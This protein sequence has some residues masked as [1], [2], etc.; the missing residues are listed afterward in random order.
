MMV[1]LIALGGAVGAVARYLVDRFVQARHD[2]V[3]PWGT[4]VANVLACLLFGFVAA[5][6]LPP[7]L[8]TLLAVG[9]L[10]ALSTYSTFAYETLRLAQNRARLLALANVA[11]SVTAGLG[12]A[13]LGTALADTV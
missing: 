8:F 1:V 9:F 6:G 2:S 10:G 5:L 11:A 13:V 3:F 4:H 7:W 12:A